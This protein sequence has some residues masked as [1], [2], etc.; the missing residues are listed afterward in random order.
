MRLKHHFAIDDLASRVN[1]TYNSGERII[2]IL[3]VDGSTIECH[4]NYVR[5]TYTYYIVALPPRRKF[6]EAIVLENLRRVSKIISKIPD[7][8]IKSDSGEIFAHSLEDLSD[9]LAYEL[10]NG[11]DVDNYTIS[12]VDITTEIDFLTKEYE[13]MHPIAKNPRTARRT[14]FH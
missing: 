2:K 4:I 7:L 14:R 8:I 3:L 1:R 5:N 9:R 10:A 13:K 12:F 6:D 11:L